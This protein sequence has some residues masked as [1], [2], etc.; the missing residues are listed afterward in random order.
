MDQEVYDNMPKTLQVRECGITVGRPGYRS[1]NIT[2]VSTIISD[3]MASKSE[4]GDLYRL[5]WM[6]ELYFANIKVTLNMDFIRSK[7]PSMV[8]KEILMTLLAYNLIRKIMLDAAISHQ[9]L[10]FNVSFKG[11]VQTINEY[12]NLQYSSNLNANEVYTSLLDAIARR[13]V[14]NRPGRVEPRAVKKRPKAF[15]RLKSSRAA[16]RRKIRGRKR[17]HASSF[18]DISKKTVNA[19][20]SNSYLNKNQVSATS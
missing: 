13:Q 5:R 2:I 15:P 4:L 7:T 17:A 14:G 9:I 18:K 11:A 16:A 6:A 3:K 19:Y 8:R 10:P 1:K 12:K 20:E